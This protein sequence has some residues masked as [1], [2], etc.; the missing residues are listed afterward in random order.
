LKNNNNNNNNN[1][2]ISS[3]IHVVLHA[4]KNTDTVLTMTSHSQ[5]L[6]FS[7]ILRFYRSVLHVE[8]RK[9]R[10]MLNQELNVM[11]LWLHCLNLIST[12]SENMLMLKSSKLSQ[13]ND[14]LRINDMLVE[15]LNIQ[16]KA[17]KLELYLMCDRAHVTL[18]HM[19]RVLTPPLTRSTLKIIEDRPIFTYKIR[20]FFCTNS[21]L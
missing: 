12:V 14:V 3:I 11:L 7:Q 13:N 18:S 5:L 16:E 19:T 2:N 6:L 4:R 17:T 20:G 8:S 15:M 10:Q 9:L 21:A 1:N